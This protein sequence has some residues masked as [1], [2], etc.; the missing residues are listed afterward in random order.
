[1][2]E[3]EGVVEGRSDEKEVPWERA[4]PGSLDILDIMKG[5]DF[6]RTLPGAQ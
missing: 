2:G 6:S 3:E 5:L 1:M 4:K